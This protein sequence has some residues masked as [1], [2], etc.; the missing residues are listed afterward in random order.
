MTARVLR[1]ETLRQARLW[2]SAKSFYR[3]AGLC[4]A[5]A[6]TAAWGHA[7][8]FR[9]VPP[10]CAACL[11]VV[12]SFPDDARGEWRCFAN[13]KKRTN[14]ALMTFQAGSEVCAADPA[15]NVIRSTPRHLC[16]GAA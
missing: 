8:S 2:D 3:Q 12:L 5:C 4:H 6:A 15:Q 9:E 10:P 14:A 11:S 16:G 1:P 7:F 13:Q